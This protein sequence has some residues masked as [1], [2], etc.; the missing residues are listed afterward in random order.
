MTTPNPYLDFLQDQPKAAYFSYADQFGGRDQS[1]G[2]QNYYQNQFSNIYDK[3]LGTLGSQARNRAQP[4]GTFN[5]FVGGFNFDD[6]Y[7]QSVPYSTRQSSRSG[8]VPRM[9]WQVPGITT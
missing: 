8:M 3:Y 7:R 1:R 4:T 9:R 6:Y 5:D 2:Q